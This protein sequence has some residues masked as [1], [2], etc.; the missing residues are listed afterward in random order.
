MMEDKNLLKLAQEVEEHLRVV[1]KIQRRPLETEIAREGLTGPQLSVLHALIESDRVTL[2]ELSNKVTLSHSTVSGIVDRLE[3]RRIVER[4]AHES[5][6][7]FTRIAV[8]KA[9]RKYLRDT[10]PSLTLHPMMT[11]LRD[12][13]PEQ[14]ASILKGLRTLRQLLE[15]NAQTKTLADVPRPSKQ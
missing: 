12:A 3:A 13:S 9:V 5:D 7:R 10:L 8:S 2:S 14:R 4:V 6:R 1:G 15:S 11:A